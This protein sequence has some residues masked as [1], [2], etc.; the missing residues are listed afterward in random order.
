MLL[1]LSKIEGFKG[2]YVVFFAV[3]FPFIQIDVNFPS[4]NSRYIY[5]DG[6]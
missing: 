6:S 1:L 2:I 4:P 3:F 5:G